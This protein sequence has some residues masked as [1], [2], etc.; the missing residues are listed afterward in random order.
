VVIIRLKDFLEVN[1]ESQS[2]SLFGVQRI[3]AEP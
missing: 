2:Q 3:A 1:K